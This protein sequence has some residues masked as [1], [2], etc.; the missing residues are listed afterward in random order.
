MNVIF[1]GTPDYAKVILERL[2]QTPD[3]CR[4]YLYSTR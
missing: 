3:K 4:S 1:M 2:I